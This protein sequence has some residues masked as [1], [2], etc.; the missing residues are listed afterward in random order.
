MKILLDTCCIIWAVSEPDSLSDRA[1]GLLA[2]EE[3]EIFFSPISG[4]EIAIAASWSI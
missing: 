3:S 2:D 4:A 1:K